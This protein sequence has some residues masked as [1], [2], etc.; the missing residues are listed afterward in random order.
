MVD[1]KYKIDFKNVYSSV[2]KN[3][4]GADDPKY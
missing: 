2:L 4:W 3:W 1:L